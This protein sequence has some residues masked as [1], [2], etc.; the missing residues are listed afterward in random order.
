MAQIHAGSTA[1]RTSVG[2]GY[3]SVCVCE[4]HTHHAQQVAGLDGV[5]ARRTLGIHARNRGGDATIGFRTDE[6]AREQAARLVGVPVV[7]VADD[8]L[9]L[10]L[11][12]PHDGGSETHA[13][14]VP[15]FASRNAFHTRSDVAGMSR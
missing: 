7:A 11:R 9:V 15:A 14:A 3:A 4:C 10:P 5:R 13:E 2:E 12:Q 1:R 8:D 6:S